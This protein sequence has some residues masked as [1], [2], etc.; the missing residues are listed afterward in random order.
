[1]N[2]QISV[3]SESHRI[4]L[5]EQIYKIQKPKS[6]CTKTFQKLRYFVFLFDGSVVRYSITE[7]LI[8]NE[9]HY[10][11]GKWYKN[12]STGFWTPTHF[13]INIP[14]EAFQQLASQ[15]SEDPGHPGSI[16]FNKVFSFPN[17][18][19][20]FRR[21]CIQFESD[22]HLEKVYKSKEGA[23]CVASSIVLSSRGYKSLVSFLQKFVAGQV[24]SMKLR[25]FLV[26]L[27][28]LLTYILYLSFH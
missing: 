10:N 21:Y 11:I 16:V 23:N 22:V 15:L 5:E 19:Y 1:M 12:P 17:W 6:T 9:R 27:E 14:C 3:E 18:N 8:D 7:Q 25:F 24:E 2:S 4:Q 20:T 26:I 13:Q 28:I